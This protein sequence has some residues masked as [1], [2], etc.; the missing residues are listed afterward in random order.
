MLLNSYNQ[1][2]T[3]APVSKN[4]CHLSAPQPR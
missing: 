4:G 1:C 3:A 2:T